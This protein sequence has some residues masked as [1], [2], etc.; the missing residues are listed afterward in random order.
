MLKSQAT[1]LCS[2]SQDGISVFVGGMPQALHS[3][4]GSGLLNISAL[5]AVP[6]SNSSRF[7]V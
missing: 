2:N 7:P 5:P 4:W 3:V 6:D 1:D